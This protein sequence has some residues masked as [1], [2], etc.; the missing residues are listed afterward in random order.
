MTTRTTAELRIPTVAVPA[1]VQVVHKPIGEAELFVADARRSRGQLL[2]A[3]ATMLDG[4]LEFVPLRQAGGVRLVPK[5]AIVWVAIRRRDPEA[6]ASADFSLEEPS[7]V[8][9]LYDRYHEVEI[10]LAGLTL[11]GMLLESSPADRPRVIDYLNRVPRFVRLWTSEELVLINKRMI[12][13]VTDQPEPE[14]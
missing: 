8:L 6:L 3:V 14:A 1:R 5:D 9:T 2:D 7:E 10:E 12:V 13:A 4:P 11:A